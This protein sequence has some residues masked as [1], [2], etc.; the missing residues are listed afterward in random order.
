MEELDNDKQI[1]LRSDEV[2]EIMGEVPSLIERCGIIFL[3]VLVLLFLVICYFLKFPDSLNA[4]VILT[5][6]TPPV[7]LHAKVSGQLI[8]INARDKQRV[9]KGEIL[10]VLDNTADFRDVLTVERLYTDWQNGDI[11]LETLLLSLKKK[12]WNLGDLQIDLNNFILS[13]EDFTV[14]HAEN[15]YPQKI[16][17]LREEQLKRQE[18]ERYQVDVLELEKKQIELASKIFKR[19]SVLHDKNIESGESYDLSFQTYLQ[20]CK[21]AIE[22]IR[23]YKESDLQKI[24]DRSTSLDL[25]HEYKQT[26]TNI[27]NSLIKSGYQLDSKIKL[28]IQTYVLRSP[29]NGVVNLMGIWSQHQYVA[30]GELVFIVLPDKS[31]KPIGK[32]ML[33]AA[34]AGKVEIGQ[35]V[36]V[37][38]NN[39]PD[40]EY[41]FLIGKVSSMSEIPDENANYF[42]EIEF[43]NG[44]RTNYDKT[45]PISKQ[46]IG[47]AQII[48]ADKRLIESLLEPVYKI[49]KESH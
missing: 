16:A 27:S 19:D 31:D 40:K 21:G 11:S 36:N 48:I 2:Q 1:E 28:W 15:Y 35:R 49:L 45:L 43:P 44:L 12:N 17:L 33:P 26:S 37:R 38:L 32:A 46:M 41:G 6:A 20:S 29:I 13:I 9:K 8:F 39:Y 4:S 14:Y 7:E 25:Q 42:I 30:S 24:L 3:G 22:N 34:G 10:A 18:L 5:T 23:T 47:S